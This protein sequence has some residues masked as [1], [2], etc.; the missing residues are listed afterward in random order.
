M[1]YLDNCATTKPYKEVLETFV[2]VNDNYYG[3]PASINKFGKTTNKLLDAARKQVADILKVK[4]ETIYFTSCA[5][6][7]NNIAI[8]GSVEHKKDFGNRIIVSK[9]EHPSVLETYRE[10]ERRGFIL[11]YLNVDSNGLIDLNHLKSLLTKETILLSVMHVN[12]VYGGVQPIKEI[13]ELLKEYPKV[14]FHVDGVQGVLKKEINLSDI[15]SYSFSA[16]KFHGIK[17]VGVLYL[18]S[19]RT[20]HNITF[21]GGQENGLRSGTVNVAGAVSLAKALRLS[22]ERTPDVLKKHREFKKLI[23]NELDS[24]NH[25]VI[26]SPLDDN[27]VDSIINI[28][29][30]KIKGEAIVNSLN[31][32]GIM[33]STTSACS[34]KTFHLNEALY[35]R[36]LSKENIEG[37]IRVSFSYK[38]KLEEIKTFVKVFKEEYNKKFKEVIES[39]I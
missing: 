37:S 3:N 34:S 29:L 39:G 20:V 2:E 8:I 15:D 9:I 33:V 24:I 10:L 6:E 31:E 11:D 18:K 1:I 23:I 30:P 35:A 38:T 7:S 26:N 17:G 12:N 19:R 5:T 28:S 14:H 36:G 21:G 4:K 13:V 32:R 25:V 27:Y 22:Y 16:H